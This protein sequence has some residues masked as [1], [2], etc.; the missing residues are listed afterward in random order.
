VSEGTI[1]ACGLF[2]S[3]HVEISIPV[4]S[5]D[6]IYCDDLFYGSLRASLIRYY[7]MLYYTVK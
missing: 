6:Y 5:S 7:V 1:K 3:K 2:G 4:S